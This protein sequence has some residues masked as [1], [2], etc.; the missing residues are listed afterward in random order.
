MPAFPPFLSSFFTPSFT[1]IPTSLPLLTYLHIT[2]NNNNNKTTYSSF[3]VPKQRDRGPHL[4]L[5]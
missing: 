5:T 3:L 1:Y 4:Q 2:D